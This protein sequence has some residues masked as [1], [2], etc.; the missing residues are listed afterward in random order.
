MPVLYKLFLGKYAVPGGRLQPWEV[1]SSSASFCCTPCWLCRS[2]GAVHLPD[3]CHCGGNDHPNRAVPGGQRASEGAVHGGLR[4]ALCW[5]PPACIGTSPQSSSLGGVTSLMCLLCGQGILSIHSSSPPQLIL[6]ILAASPMPA[7]RG[8]TGSTVALSRLAGLSVE[9]VGRSLD[10]MAQTVAAEYSFASRFFSTPHPMRFEGD[11]ACM[12]G[13]RPPYVSVECWAG[14]KVATV[15]LS[16]LRSCLRPLSGAPPPA[17]QRT[18]TPSL[19]APPPFL[20][21]APLFSCIF[22]GSLSHWRPPATRPAWFE[23]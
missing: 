15:L 18:Q 3:H 13:G 14:P 20:H 10:E 19:V 23:C 17:N 16:P 4:C 11:Y 22:Q 1:A 8:E 12:P 2:G 6:L 21:Q 9:A 7:E 5:P